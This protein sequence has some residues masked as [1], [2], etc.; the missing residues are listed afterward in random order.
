MCGI[1]GTHS[2]ERLAEYREAG[3]DLPILNRPVG[4]EAALAVIRAFEGDTAAATQPEAASPATA[5]AGAASG[6]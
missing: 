3:V 1:S 4:P 2:R 6:Q 5:P